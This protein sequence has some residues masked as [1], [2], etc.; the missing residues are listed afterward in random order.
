VDSRHHGVA[1]PGHRAEQVGARAQVGDLAQEFHGVLLGLDRVG[2]RVLDEAGDDD[3][4]RLKFEGLALAL[5]RHQGAA[6]DHAGAGGEVLH[7]AVVIGQGGRHHG[8]DR[9]EAGAVG[10]VDEGQ[11]GLGVAAGTHPAAHGH[12]AAGVELAGKSL[13]HA[14]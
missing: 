7:L 5:R 10:D 8:L 3:L 1:H 11:A 9:I 12:R 2:L 6:D 13:L 14:A 4:V